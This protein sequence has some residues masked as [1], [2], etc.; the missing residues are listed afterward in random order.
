MLAEA[1]GSRLAVTVLRSGAMV[2]VVA[3]PTELSPAD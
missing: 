2:D 1:I 3:H